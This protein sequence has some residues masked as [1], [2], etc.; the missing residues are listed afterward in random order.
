MSGSNV[1]PV[2]GV[3][4]LPYVVLMVG[5]GSMAITM[6]PVFYPE[7]MVGLAADVYSAALAANPYASGLADD[8]YEAALTGGSYGDLYSDL[9]RGSVYAWIDVDIDIE[10]YSTRLDQDPYRVGG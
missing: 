3:V 2:A 8:P 9:Y 10:I 5:S 1:M 6:G 4:V 7:L